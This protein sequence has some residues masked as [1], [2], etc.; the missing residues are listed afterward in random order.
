M[1]TRERLRERKEKKG[2]ESGMD[3]CQRERCRK[4]ARERVVYRMNERERVISLETRNYLVQM[5]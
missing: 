1:D 5:L 3:G 4:G 2:E